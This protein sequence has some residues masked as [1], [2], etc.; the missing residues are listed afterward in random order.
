MRDSLK[1]H[2]WETLMQTLSNSPPL[3]HVLK[4]DISHYSFVI[5]ILWTTRYPTIRNFKAL[6]QWK[7]E[8]KRSKFQKRSLAGRLS[9]RVIKQKVY[10]YRSLLQQ[11]RGCLSR[12]RCIFVVPISEWETMED[13][14]APPALRYIATTAIECFSLEIPTVLFIQLNLWLARI[15]FNPIQT[16]LQDSQSGW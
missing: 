12:S 13:T 16:I 2:L 15:N 1:N 11:R 5:P 10:L 8:R 14:R 6:W 9:L 3:F 7:K 4:Q